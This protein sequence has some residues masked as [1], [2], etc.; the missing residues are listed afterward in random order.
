MAHEDLGELE[1][2]VTDYNQAIAIAP[3]DINT[4]INRALVNATLGN[5]L[6]AVA[7]MDRA[8]QIDPAYAKAYLV[9]AYAQAKLGRGNPIPSGYRPGCCPWCRPRQCGKQY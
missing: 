9:R 1:K 5:N 8:A 7:D 2:A 3:E 4:L 6:L